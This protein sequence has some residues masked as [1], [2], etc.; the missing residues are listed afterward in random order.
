MEL[1][2]VLF[3]GLPWAA[4]FAFSLQEAE[5]EWPWGWILLLLLL[6]AL[7]GVWWLLGPGART[8]RRRM[9]DLPRLNLPQAKSA[10]AP[11]P[12]TRPQTIAAVPA[13][14]AGLVSAPP[15]VAPVAAVSDAVLPAP[16]EEVDGESAVAPAEDAEAAEPGSGSKAP[17][18][19]EDPTRPPPTQPDDLRRIAGIG[20]KVAGVLNA[21]G[22]F[23]FA[24]LADT[25]VE[26]LG[27]I[28]EAEGLKF[29]KPDTWPEQAAFAAQD[30][31]DGL[32]NLQEQIKSG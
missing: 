21:G 32:I 4:Q 17:A 13:P 5:G 7:L 2:F 27:E 19:A 24:Q 8:R 6:A 9:G 28:L 30:D 16:E 15:E 10:P 25:S 1:G 14:G 11:Q 26:R 29:M 31:W 12:T 3:A 18:E 22:I 23:T 20:P